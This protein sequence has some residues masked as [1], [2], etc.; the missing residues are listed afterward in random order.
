[1]GYEKQAVIHGQPKG[2]ANII[3]AKHLKGNAGI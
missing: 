1:L 2:H 3:Y